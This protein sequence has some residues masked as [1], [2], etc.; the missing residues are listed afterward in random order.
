MKKKK[1]FGRGTIKK[2]SKGAAAH[3]N[4]NS[5]PGPQRRE[6]VEEFL[7]RGGEIQQLPGPTY[8][9]GEGHLPFFSRERF[10]SSG[11]SM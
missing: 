11:V 10:N 7:A 4:C 3:L 9:I 2:R 8:G 5:G 6:T 1:G